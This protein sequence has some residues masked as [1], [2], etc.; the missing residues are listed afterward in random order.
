MYQEG[1]FAFEPKTFKFLTL[2][3]I[4]ENLIFLLVMHGTYFKQVEYMV[5]ITTHL[6]PKYFNL[7]QIPHF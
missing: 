3:W 2:G 4:F 7:R 6:Q 5:D 1:K